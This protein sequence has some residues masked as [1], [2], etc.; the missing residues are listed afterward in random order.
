VDAV[1]L[2]EA[3]L[4]RDAVEQERHQRRAVG[5]RQL[6]VDGAEAPAVGLPVVRQGFHGREH[7][8]R[9]RLLPFRLVEDRL[10]ALARGLGLL[11]PQAVVRPRLDDEDGHG[12]AQE[13]PQAPPGAGRGLPAHPGV[14]HA[15]AQARRVDLPLH[16]GGIRLL[17]VE[18]EAGG[19][20]RPDEEDDRPVVGDRDRGRAHVRGGGSLPPT[21]AATRPEREAAQQGEPREERAVCR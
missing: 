5:P 4:A 20:A 16:E 18:A 13:P 8:L 1:G 7:E 11:A 10:D 2:V 19:Q 21:A 6:R 14:D 3:R 12:L 9:R 15:V 17:R